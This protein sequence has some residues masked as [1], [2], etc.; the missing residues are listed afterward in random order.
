MALDLNDD[1]SSSCEEWDLNEV[2]SDHDDSD[3]IRSSPIPLKPLPGVSVPPLPT[4]EAQ[5]AAFRKVLKD[6]PV[7]SS[8]SEVRG[9]LTYSFDFWLGKHGCEVECIS[10]DQVE[11]GRWGSLEMEL[12]YTE[13]E[14][15]FDEGDWGQGYEQ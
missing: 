4:P 5:L 13:V 9:N 3:I 6:H 10:W 1:V 7:S 11:G 8:S 12:D 14:D 2:P 15:I